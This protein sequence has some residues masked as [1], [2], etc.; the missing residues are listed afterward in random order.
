MNILST[1]TF[2]PRPNA[3]QRIQQAFS[4][5][6]VS[7]LQPKMLGALLLPFLVAVVGALLLLWFFWTPLKEMLSTW[8]TQ[9]GVFDEHAEWW[10]I[11][12][13]LFAIKTVIIPLLA[14]GTLLPIA[15]IVGLMVAAVLVMPIALGAVQKSH[16]PHLKRLGRNAFTYSIWNA[17]VVGFVFVVGWILTM[18][19]WL[20][21]PL[22]VLL[23]I[24]WWGFA[25]TRLLRVD[26]IVEHAS[27]KERRI[28]LQRHNKEYWLIGLIMSLLNL[29]PPA[30]LILPVFSALVFVHFNLAALAQ[31]RSETVLEPS[32]II[33]K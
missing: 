25:F 5:A 29:L 12:A 2:A 19:L 28:L 22:A 33:I 26:S 6:I 30:W 15:G 13:G 4:R 16:F 23:P 24:C 20:F 9:W 32:E 7:Q 8:L 14:I 31:L 18:P 17:L 21:G 1:Q 3:S 10:L 27:A 11:G